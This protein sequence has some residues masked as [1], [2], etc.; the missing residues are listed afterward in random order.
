MSKTKLRIIQDYV[1]FNEDKPN[2][3]YLH[4][5]KDNIFEQYALIVGP[6]N[7]PYFGG[8]YI[9]K[10]T[11]PKNYPKKPPHVIMQTTNKN[12]RFN[13]NLYEAGK[14]CLSILGTWAGPSW[15]E[16]MNIR[17]VLLSIQ[18]LMNEFPIRNEPGYEN[19]KDDD[20]HSIDYNNFIN[21]YNYKIAI[22]DILNNIVQFKNNSK[23]IGH[24]EFFIDPIINEFKKNYKKLYID[25][26]SY[27]ITIGIKEVKK[28]TVY[29]IRQD[30]T[31]DFLN[32]QKD[33]LNSFNL[34]SNNFL[35]KIDLI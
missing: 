16:V 21:F 8:Y 9:F 23:K 26:Q 24:I 33:L 20:Y 22:I 14:V 32:L 35:E 3:I 27:M 6:H 34:F 11:Y 10:I 15:E 4:I 17:L 2:G 13:P 31:I 1:K 29:F 19:T 25:I 28:N 7:T 5:N 18:S 30:H 12:V